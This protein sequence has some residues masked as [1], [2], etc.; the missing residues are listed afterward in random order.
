MRYGVCQVNK[1]VSSV[2]DDMLLAALLAGKE[3]NSFVFM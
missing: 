3:H 1:Y 2:E